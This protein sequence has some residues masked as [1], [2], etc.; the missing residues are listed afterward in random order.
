M[1]IIES[2][3]I[4]M[5]RVSFICD[6]C[7]KQKTIELLSDSDPIIEPDGWKSAH[8]PESDDFLY[9]ETRSCMSA[10]YATFVRV[11]YGG[12]SELPPRKRGTRKVSPIRKAKKP[13][14]ESGSMQIEQAA[15]A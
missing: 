8:H 13:V 2:P 14:R 1:P 11:L 3:V 6:R 15:E 4:A 7:G 12:P 9:F 5:R 10:W